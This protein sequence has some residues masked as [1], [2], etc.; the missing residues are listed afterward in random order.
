MASMEK[1]VEKYYNKFFDLFT[2][3]GW[4]QLIEELK[5]NA[6]SV[7]SVEAVKDSD[8]MYFRKGQLNILAFLLN[9]ESTVN[10]NFEELQKE[11]E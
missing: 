1:E 5:H 10:N 9:L 2:T 3:D 6:I 8:D 7:N 4:K 11:D